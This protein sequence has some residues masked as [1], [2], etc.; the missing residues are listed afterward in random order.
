MIIYK[1]S[2]LINDKIY[3]GQTIESLNKRWRRHTWSC[4]KKRNAMAITNAIVKYGVE[5]FIIEEIDNAENIEEL[6]TKE[7]YYIKYYNCISP[8]GYNIKAGG[9]N[10]KLSEE[11]KQKISNSNKGKIVTEETRKNLSESHKG[12]IPSEE[13]RQKWRDAFSGKRPSDNTINA[14]IEAHQ[15][16]YTLLNPDGEL[17]TFINMAK[18]CRDNNLS[19]AKLCLVASGKRKFHKGWSKPI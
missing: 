17:I 10:K 19:N 9:G 15:K 13:T 16:E 5:N 12:W 6:N 8:N 4:T 2:N 7:E 1:I 3:I 14:S 18:F 11:T